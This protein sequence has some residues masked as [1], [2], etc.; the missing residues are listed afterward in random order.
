MIDNNSQLT[1]GGLGLGLGIG[2]H[3]KWAKS[4]S[5]VLIMFDVDEEE[6]KLVLHLC[7]IAA[8]DDKGRLYLYR[9]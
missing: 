2:L 8:Y 7:F 1:V 9:L 6:P 4:L 3:V 5:M